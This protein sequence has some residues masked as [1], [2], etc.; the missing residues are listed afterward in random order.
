[1]THKSNYS[2]PKQASICY[3]YRLMRSGVTVLFLVAMLIILTNPS[4]VTADV[5]HDNGP[6]ITG[7]GPNPGTDYYS[8]MTASGSVYGYSHQFTSGYRVADDFTITS[9]EWNISEIQFY[10]YQP[11]SGTISPITAVYLQIWNGRPGDVGSSVI[12]GDLT[13]NRMT[14]TSFT[15]IYRISNATPNTN[16]PVMVQTVS[17]GTTLSTGT[18]WLDWMVDGSVSYTGP[19]ANP[20]QYAGVNGK[21]GA[22]ARNYISSWGNVVDSGNGAA[23][24][25]PFLIMGTSIIPTITEWSAIIIGVLLLITGGWFISRKVLG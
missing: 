8:E 7:A 15:N 1:M 5:L 11:S 20:V 6:M 2:P 13:T 25:F 12:W 18:Y 21:P 19:W 4:Y 17:V 24:D 22:N 10:A 16:R 9:Q 14:S 3:L 23:Q